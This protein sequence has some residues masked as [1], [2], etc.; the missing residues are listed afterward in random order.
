MSDFI[1]GVVMDIVSHFILNNLQGL[2][3]VWVATSPWDFAVL[4]AAEF[5]VLDP[6]IGLEY[7]E[8]RCKPEQSGITGSDPRLNL[9]F[10]AERC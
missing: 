1:I 6:K 7:L 10:L 8:R 3:L 2:S 9:N 5:V 4:D